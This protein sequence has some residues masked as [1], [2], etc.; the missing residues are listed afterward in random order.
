[1][2]HH[3]WKSALVFIA[4]SLAA[5]AVAAQAKA[6]AYP[7]KPVRLIVPVPP[8]QAT[9]VAAR[10]LA[11]ELAK[12]WGKAVY[13][14]NKLGGAAI[15]GMVA[16]KDAAADGYSFTL[17]TSAAMVMNP[18]LFS[19]LPYDTPVDFMLVHGLFRNPLLIVANAGAPYNSVPELVQAAKKQPGKLNWSYP[20]MGNTQHLTGELFKHM[21]G[22]EMENIIYKGSAQ[23]VTDLLSNQVSI[24]VDSVAAVLP[25][26]K[27]GKLKPLA[28]TGNRRAPQLPEV[29]TL[30][31]VGYKDFD[32]Q[33]FGGILAPKGTPPAIVA[34]VGAD[35]GAV[36]ADPAFQAK[37]ADRGLV[38][39]NASADEW[40]KLFSSELVKWAEVAKRANIQ[41]Q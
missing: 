15:P 32:G 28:M 9:D 2:N 38:V 10:L 40:Q 31:E 3:R 11:E 6:E 13:V 4:V 16:G 12:K 21:A 34:K 14:E 20:G 26:I 30:A 41:P 24:G 7:A 39:Y 8:G 35:I 22:I 37:F 17:G 36:L 19:K 33:G 29:P 18:Q 5:G 23:A 27:A 25:H 1:M